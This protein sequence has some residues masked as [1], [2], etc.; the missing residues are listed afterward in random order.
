MDPNERKKKLMMGFAA[1]LLFLILISLPMYISYKKF[2]KE[3][4]ETIQHMSTTEVAELVGEDASSDENNRKL[5]KRA[6]SGGDWDLSAS[7]SGGLP[8]NRRTSS[9][10]IEDHPKT[11]TS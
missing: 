4:D 5:V 6:M 9:R 8:N 1:N 11:P 2:E 7:G 3:A 10:L